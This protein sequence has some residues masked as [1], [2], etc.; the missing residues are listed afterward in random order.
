M[1]LKKL[2]ENINLFFVLGN[3]KPRHKKAVLKHE[4]EKEF[5]SLLSELC[6]N[7][8]PEVVKQQT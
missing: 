7:L 5:I 2:N 3:S 8:R 1:K 4:V 6:L